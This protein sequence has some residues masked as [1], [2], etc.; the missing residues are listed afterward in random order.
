[1]KEPKEITIHYEPGKMIFET[2]GEAF[3]MSEETAGSIFGRSVGIEFERTR[4][5]DET[6]GGLR[7]LE[8]YVRIRR[9]MTKGLRLPEIAVVLGVQEARVRQFYA[10]ERAKPHVESWGPN[11]LEIE[12]A[13]QAKEEMDFVKEADREPTLAEQKGGKIELEEKFVDLLQV[14]NLRRQGKSDEG[15]AAW[16]NLDKKEFGKFLDLNRRYLDLLQ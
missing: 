16:L 4:D 6:F 12:R 8:N 15:I 3:Y 2:D 11:E 13:K 10:T 14:R 7:S 1:M 5:Q 9:L